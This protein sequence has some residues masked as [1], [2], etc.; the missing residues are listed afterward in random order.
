MSSLSFNWKRI[1]ETPENSDDVRILIEDVDDRNRKK[2]NILKQPLP[3]LK[4][5]IQK[6]QMEKFFQLEETIEKVKKLSKKDLII[7]EN[8]KKTLETDLKQFSFNEDFTLKRVH[9]LF[10]VNNYLYI[11]YW[12]LT[13]LRG[14]KEKKKIQPLIILDATISMNRIL[15]KDVI[16]DESYKSGFVFFNTKMNSLINESFYNLLFQNPKMLYQSS[17]QKFNKEI[18]LYKEQKIILDKIKSAIDTDI[19]LLLGNQMPT[20]QGKTFLSVPL[21]KMLSMEKN[22]KKKKCVLFACSNELV[23]MDVASNALVGNDIHLWMAK[24]LLI[25]IKDKKGDI[26]KRDFRVLLRPYKSCFPN[27]WKTV[28]KKKEDEKFKNGTIHEQWDYY[29]KATGKIPDII[30]ADLE[31]CYQLLEYQSK[32]LKYSN[33]EYKKNKKAYFAVEDNI[34]PFI[35]YIDEFISDDKSNQK[36]VKICK[37]L[38]RQTVLL[39][40]VLPKFEY[41][42]SIVRNFCYRHETTEEECCSRVSS[43]DISIPCC[44]VSPDGYATFPH[45]QVSDK[46]GLIELIYQMNINP[47]IRRTYSPKDVYFLA[48]T[49]EDIL[50]TE[51]Q[52]SKQFP[53]IGSINM[54]DI[55]NYICSLL[56][57]LKDN[58]QY[59][60]KFQEYRPK[61][62]NPIQKE[63]IF[64]SQSWE[65]EPKTLVVMN[66][67]L[68]QVIHL[69]E[70][71]F[72]DSVK[73]DKL[74]IENEKNREEL[75]KKLENIKNKKFSSSDRKKGGLLDKTDMLDRQ[76]LLEDDYYNQNVSIPT[77]MILN[78]M[79]HFKRY[80]KNEI[81][82][83]IVNQLPCPSLKEEYFSNFSDN[84]IYQLFS[85]IGT[86]DAE[87]QT[88]FQRNLIMKLYRNLSFFC[89]GKEIVYGTNLSGLVNIFIDNDFMKSINIPELYQLM[90]RVGR[91]GRSYH[92]NIIT[93]SQETVDKLLSF[94]ESFESDNDIEKLF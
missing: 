16:T 87:Q 92:A 44:I 39:S 14:L 91:M 67:P 54:K 38:P 17:F 64:T 83:K 23:N 8:E 68:K 59:L 1:E 60:A 50:P 82:P 9:F 43:T 94:D 34:N 84:E 53:N 88:E 56:L 37:Y 31:S 72:K 61:I 3:I 42:P 51:F 40:S 24:N 21:A 71:L 90:G 55:T 65:Y 19:P 47:R 73:V 70:D 89:S 30:V 86:Y 20:G 2:G 35:A 6:F 36:M 58:I 46:E 78:H 5:F 77:S 28:Y 11:L 7:L 75:K 18:H 33:E 62:M 48:K 79:D 74:L 15:L 76:S 63:N 12:C 27:T 29:I 69:T 85:G 49:I 41:I 13:I 80:N 26:I 25:D 4:G 66:D 32:L 81:P 22:K 45:H 93:M 57:F 10:P 52:F